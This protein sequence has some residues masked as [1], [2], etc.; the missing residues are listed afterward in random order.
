MYLYQHIKFLLYPQRVEESKRNETCVEIDM[1][2]FS[3]V[4]IWCG[5]SLGNIRIIDVRT[6]Q[7][8]MHL[9][10]HLQSGSSSVLLLCPS[11][12]SSYQYSVWTAMKTGKER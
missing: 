3:S 12:D 10:H 6:A 7:L 5:C 11:R 8:S 2:I 1:R 4:E 9:S